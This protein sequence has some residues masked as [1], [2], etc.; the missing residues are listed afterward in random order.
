MTTLHIESLGCARNDVDSEE[1]AGRFAAA[2]YE[3]VEESVDAEVVVINTCGFIEAAKQESIDEILTAARL[4]DDGRVR[5]VVATGCLAQR[6][7]SDLAASLPEADGIIGFDGYDDIASTVEAILAGARVDAPQPRD[8]RLILPIA[9][10]ARRGEDTPLREPW[11]PSNRVRLSGSPMAALKI[12]SGCDRR[13]AFCAIPSFRGAFQSRPMDE[14]VAEA[15]WLAG[16]GVKE[17]F[18]VSE[19]TTSYGKDLDLARPL[20]S[21]LARL[22]EIDGIEWIRLSYLQPAEVRP[23]LIEAVASTPKV[24][25]Y[26]DLP[27]QHGSGSVLRRM[28]R[29]GAAD[30]FLGLLERVRQ[31]I[32]NAGVRSNVIVG[33]PGETEADVD[34]LTDFLGEASLD[35]VGVFPYSDEEGTEGA[36][37]DGHLD[38][39]EIAARAADVAQFADTVCSIQ[40][41][42]RL[43]QTVEVLVEDREGGETQGR[44]S[45]QG[46]ED[47]HTVVIGGDWSVGQILRGRVDG[48]DG[49]DWRVRPQ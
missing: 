17:L 9:P 37:L 10:A 6:Y 28:R 48:V 22:A 23:S 47:G 34:M 27:F 39:A 32:P 43:G 5:T 30:S 42:S 7:G 11:L 33:F 8:R 49:V 18:L 31:A 25:P 44:A 40:A 24:T 26:F 35:A 2:G 29:F 45:Q 19:N 16:Q 21:L 38:E 36:G 20:E 15:R 46:P 1:L 12:A 3:L 4:K 41:E 13:C 14:I